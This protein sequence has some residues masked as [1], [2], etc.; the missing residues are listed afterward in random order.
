MVESFVAVDVVGLICWLGDKFGKNIGSRK[1]N[2]VG[3]DSRSTEPNHVD[4]PSP[5]AYLR[6]SLPVAAGRRQST[7]GSGCA[8]ETQRA[9]AATHGLLPLH[10]KHEHATCVLRPR[11]GP[12][13]RGRTA[14]RPRSVAAQS[15]VAQV[16]SRTYPA[17]ATIGRSRVVAAPNRP[18]LYSR[19]T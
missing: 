8:R 3:R 16:P 7:I 2:G 18:R 12:H 1:A 5:R 9:C 4:H 14:P 10:V 6:L 13:A 15:D 11:W 17:S 19:Q